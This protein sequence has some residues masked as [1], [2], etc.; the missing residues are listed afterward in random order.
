ME[1][2]EQLNLAK[3]SSR[4]VVNYSDE[5]INQ[6][7]LKLADEIE[8]NINKILEANKEDID[9]MNADDPKLSRLVLDKNKIFGIAQSMRDVSK[10][11]SPLNKVLEERKLENGLYLSRIS[12]PLGVVGVIYEARPNVTPDIFSLCIKS[13]NVCVLKGGKDAYQSHKVFVDIIKSVLEKNKMDKNCIQLLSSDRKVVYDLLSAKGLVDLVVARGS[14]NLIDFVQENAKVPFIETGA[15]VAHA[16]F[17]KGSDAQIGKKIIENSKISRPAVC[18]ALDTLIVHKDEINNLSELVSMLIEHKVELFADE[19]SYLSLQGKYPES[20]L[21]KAQ[22]EHFDTEFLS[23]K[24]AIKIV[25]SLEEAIKHIDKYGT[26]HTE[27]ILSK[28][29]NNIEKFLKQ[30]DAAAVYSNCSTVFTDGGVY[31]LGAEIG[32][33]TQKLHARGPMGLNALTS[34]KW[35]L[36]GNGQVRV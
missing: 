16:Y 6:M 25:S 32:I 9:K 17:D 5:K 7:L 26:G 33:S 1:I 18:N 21:K 4:E 19:Q 22:I 29:E 14:R 31:G 34:Y 12:V 2:K 36:R 23:L 13:G 30:V 27:V 20:L 28:N 3:K 24:M 10:L 11:P 35:I 15:G 8:K